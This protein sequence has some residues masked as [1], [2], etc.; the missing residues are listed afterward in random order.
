[1]SWH[2]PTAGLLCTSE[3][4]PVP[5]F[6]QVPPPRRATAHRLSASRTLGLGCLFYLYSTRLCDRPVF[7][8]LSPGP[9]SF[10]KAPSRHTH[11]TAH[12][13]VSFSPV[14]GLYSAVYR[15]RTSFA[16]PPVSAHLGYPCPSWGLYTRLPFFMPCYPP[17][18]SFLPTCPPTSLFHMRLH[19]HIVMNI[20]RERQGKEVKPWAGSCGPHESRTLRERD[21]WPEARG[22]C[23]GAQTSRRGAAL[24]LRTSKGLPRPTP[25]QL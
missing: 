20:S 9:A 1:M 12:V 5:L 18:P 6:T 22:P 23:G 21:R 16:H 2:V 17:P 3:R 11:I 7:V 15:H 24:A 19:T 14:A 13:Q 8:L 10:R 4:A 25:L